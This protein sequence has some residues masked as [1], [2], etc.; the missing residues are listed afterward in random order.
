M[1][2]KAELNV[3]SLLHL[4]PIQAYRELGIVK[5][6]TDPEPVIVPPLPEGVF[7][8]IYA[9]PP[10]QVQNSEIHRRFSPLV[11]WR[12]AELW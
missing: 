12:L 9:D 1:Y 3:T 4:T 2:E 11:A 6:P 7:N 8:V 5:D 10:W